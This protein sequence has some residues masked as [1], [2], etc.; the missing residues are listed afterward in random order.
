MYY[1]EDTTTTPVS[2]VNISNPIQV[3]VY[4]NPADGVTTI[5]LGQNATE[6]KVI[7]CDIQGRKLN[8]YYY[9][10]TRKVQP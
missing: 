7:I 1:R 3:S 4:P 5:D 8:E 10:N 2:V 6:L 9:S